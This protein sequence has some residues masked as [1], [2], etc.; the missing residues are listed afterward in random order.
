MSKTQPDT[1]E[2]PESTNEVENKD[3]DEDDNDIVNTIVKKCKV[4]D[5]INLISPDSL[6]RSLNQ[7][8]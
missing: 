3:Y 7:K 6:S 2:K 4:Y 8:S 5:F 1:D